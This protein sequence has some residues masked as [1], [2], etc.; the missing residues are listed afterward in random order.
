M[1]SQNTV[2]LCDLLKYIRFLLAPRNRVARGIVLGLAETAEAAHVGIADLNVLGLNTAVLRY[3]KHLRQNVS[4]RRFVHDLGVVRPP[5]VDG[6]DQIYD[7][8]FFKPRSRAT[9]R[10]W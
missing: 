9:P 3:K 7:P 8:K 10:S 6:N 4:P 2:A 1:R 5:R